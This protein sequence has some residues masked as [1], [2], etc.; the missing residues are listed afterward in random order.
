MATPTPA[1]NRTPTL[2]E[3]IEQIEKSLPRLN[4]ISLLRAQDVSKQFNGALGNVIEIVQAVIKLQGD[5]FDARV[6][7]E[8]NATRVLGQLVE[9]GQLLAADTVT[10]DAVV[11]GN[12]FDGEGNPTPLAK[13]QVEFSSFIPA[14]KEA[15]LGRGVGAKFQ[16]TD[17]GFEVTAIYVPNRNYQPP[18]P[19]TET[20]D[21]STVVA[22][23]SAAQ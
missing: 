12:E 16:G 15:L 17:G 8:D 4:E 18:A 22:A 7:D 21:A 10:E 19:S 2:A 11:V 5:G 20:V 9:S 6:Q 1:V 3:R 23:P 13:A 14:A